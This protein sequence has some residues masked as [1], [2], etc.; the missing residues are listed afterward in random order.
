MSKN[1]V[2]LWEITEILN[3]LQR[4]E[5]PLQSGQKWP[6]YILDRF[7]AY[8]SFVR[9]FHKARIRSQEFLF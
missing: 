2:T 5:S 4:N 8:R 6:E 9:N 1:V 3:E 7:S